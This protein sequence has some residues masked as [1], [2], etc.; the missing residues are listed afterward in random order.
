MTLHELVGQLRTYLGDVL[1]APNDTWETSDLGYQWMNPE[2]VRHL[3]AAR[4]EYCLR[5]PIIDPVTFQVTLTA[6]G[7]GAAE[8]EPVVL[9]VRRVSVSGVAVPAMDRTNLDRVR[10]GWETETGEVPYAY[11]IDDGRPLRMRLVPMPTVG[12][13]ARLEVF[14]LPLEPL[15]WDARTSEIEELPSSA[16][17]AQAVVWWAAHLAFLMRDEDLQDPKQ[18]ELAYQAFERAVGPRRDA[19]ERAFAVWASNRRPRV[20]SHL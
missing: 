16:E 17:E 12:L 1:D 6:N 7:D 11:L 13:T 15:S 9:G 20:R 3:N 2:L 10:A 8:L 4:E 5:R 14:R 18:A 19:R